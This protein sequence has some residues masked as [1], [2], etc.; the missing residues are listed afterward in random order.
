M[1]TLA[2]LAA[3]PLLV[4]SLAAATPAA[5]EDPLKP[6]AGRWRCTAADG[7]FSDRAY[8]LHDVA[9]GPRVGAKE[10]YGR[11]ELTDSY[12]I[13]RS[14]VERIGENG[15]GASVEA[16]EGS[17]SASSLAFPLRFSGQGQYAAFGLTYA[18]DRNTMQR[19][20]TRGGATV[21]DE[22]C[23][24]QPDPVPDATCTTGPV[25]TTTVHQVTPAYPKEALAAKVTG[26]VHVRVVMDDQSRVVWTDVIDSAS[27]L[28]TPAAVQ[29][30]RDSTYKTMVVNCTPMP[31][32][33]YFTVKFG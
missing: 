22:R 5:D 21:S 13:P 1:R 10:V 9:F 26:P 2:A 16:P 15:Y 29:A 17:G 32:E 14:A 12:G 28:L 7:R 8:F 24:R 18:V 6:L 23:I 11:V 25:L 27:P 30:A 4:T 33:E 3:I 19:T 31:S 20:V